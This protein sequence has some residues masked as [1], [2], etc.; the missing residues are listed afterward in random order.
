MESS[1]SQRA[2]RVPRIASRSHRPSSP[3]TCCVSSSRMHGLLNP[4]TTSRN[5]STHFVG[6]TSLIAVFPSLPPSFPLPFVDDDDN[7]E[8]SKSAFCTD[9]SCFR[10]LVRFTM[11]LFPTNAKVAPWRVLVRTRNA[12]DADRRSHAST[13]TR[14]RYKGNKMRGRE[15]ATM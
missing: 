8:D 4:L 15:L 5:S 6:E 9:T 7:G 11:A 10:N 1:K 3:S 2:S 13:C 12:T 14:I